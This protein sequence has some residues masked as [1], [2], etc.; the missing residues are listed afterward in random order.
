MG[1]RLNILRLLVVLPSWVG[2]AVMATPAC[3]RVRTHLPGV[4][5]GALARPGID[6]VLSGLDLFDEVHVERSS[7]VMGPK[8]VAAKLRPRRYDAAL[9]LTNSFSTALIT[10]I[11]G[12]P[13]RIGYN[14]DGR[15]ILLTDSLAVPPMGRGK[16]PPVPAVDYYWAAAG[17]LIER[18]KGEVAPASPSRMEL[19]ATR[20]DQQA[21]AS[22]LERAAMTTT[23]PTLPRDLAILNPG[24]NNP[25]KR[26]PVER[27]AAVGIHLVRRGVRVLVNGSPGEAELCAQIVDLIGGAIDEP[28]RVASLPHCGGTLASLKGV[29]GSGRCGVMVTNDT[30]PRHLAAAFS[31]PVVSLF[32]PT[33]PRW[34]TI[35]VD[36]GMEEILVA[37]PTLPPEEIADDHPERCRV[38][39]IE[40]GAVIEALERVIRTG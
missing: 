21:A 20:E 14:R 13:R 27:F 19:V 11:A 1:E 37:D 8:F 28:S 22:V 38:D 32:G 40:V 3:R 5:I 9:L 30:G 23:S 26:W 36:P 35:P 18:I 31:V 39:R 29:L 24:G 33:D 6:Q 15:W 16:G 17:S 34:T 25:A 4:F 12:I 10:R 7:G 2:D